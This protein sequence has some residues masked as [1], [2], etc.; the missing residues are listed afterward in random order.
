VTRE[1]I[2]RPEAEDDITEAAV[3]YERQSPGLGWDFTRTVDAWL[4]EVSRNP[5]RF[6]GFARTLGVRFCG[7]SP[8]R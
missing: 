5:L 2:V 8:S 1:F 7:G 4:A 6:P 3:W